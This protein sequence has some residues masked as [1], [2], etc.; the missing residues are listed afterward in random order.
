MMRA[1]GKIQSS[2][3]SIWKDAH[4]HHPQEWRRGSE[5]M[6]CVYY[7]NDGLKHIS[8]LA[9]EKTRRK[10]LFWVFESTKPLTLTVLFLPL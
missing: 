4:H 9:E 1:T 2:R 3:Y 7:R 6:P 10:M 8:H 5:A